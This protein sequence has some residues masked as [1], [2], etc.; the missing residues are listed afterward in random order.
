LQR[1]DAAFEQQ[2]SGDP[3]ALIAWR[4]GVQGSRQFGA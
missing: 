1:L 4:G 3:N 2:V